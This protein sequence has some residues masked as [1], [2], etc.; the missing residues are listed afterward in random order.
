MTDE[1]KQAWDG[2]ERR[3][4]NLLVLPGRRRNEDPPK[5]KSAAVEEAIHSLLEIEGTIGRLFCPI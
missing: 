1:Q 5:D 4:H 3:K 2:V